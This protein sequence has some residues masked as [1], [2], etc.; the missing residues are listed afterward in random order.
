MVR[1]GT[2]SAEQA[3]FSFF[4]TSGPVGISFCRAF[5][6]HLAWPT[7]STPLPASSLPTSFAP[8]PLFP[9]DVNVCTTWFCY[10]LR[11]KDLVACIMSKLFDYFCSYKRGSHSDG[12]PA[13]TAKYVSTPI[14]NPLGPVTTRH[15]VEKCL[16]SFNVPP[17]SL[18]YLQS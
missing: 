5:L 15:G 11:G 3:V 13:I 2:L 14:P 8:S 6:G 16:V 4:I 9:L 1:D 18:K 17:N 10:E 12:L 7:S